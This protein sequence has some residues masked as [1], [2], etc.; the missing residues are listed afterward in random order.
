MPFA[1]D[2]RL[3]N[4]KNC[5]TSYPN[6]PKDGIVYRDFLPILRNPS[7]LEDMISIFCDIIK[8]NYDQT[9][10]LF[11]LESRG[12]LLGPL[13]AAKLKLPFIPIRKSGK[14]P[15]DVKKMSY[16]LE[17]G[18]DSLEI[19]VGC[20]KKGDSVVIVDDLLATGGSLE[21][22]VALL[23]SCGATVVAC[24]VVIE[25]PELEGRKKLKVPAHA[26]VQF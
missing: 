13:I 20:V 5:I 16:S 8:T 2:E 22:S 23:E 1:S 26:L 24:L 19:Q 12:F 9:S 25:L 14:L 17:Y 4:I 21:A 3:K 10:F 7:V 15:G 11:A 18:R 6:F